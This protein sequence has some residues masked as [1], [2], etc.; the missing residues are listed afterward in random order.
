MHKI[1]KILSILAILGAGLPALAHE[2]AVDPQ[3]VAALQPGRLQRDAMPHA[4]RPVAALVARRQFAP[5]CRQLAQ[6]RRELLRRAA[7]LFYQPDRQHGS[8]SLGMTLF[9]K[10]NVE[11]PKPLLE[12]VHERLV[13]APA[14]RTLAVEACGLA[15]QPAEGALFVSDLALLAG[16]AQARLAL[17]LLR[18]QAAG[19]WSAGLGPIEAGQTGPRVALL[20]A[21][22]GH[23][24]GAEALVRE[25]G[26]LAVSSE[27]ALLVHRIAR[28]LGVAVADGAAGAAP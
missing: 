18:A 9:L 8:D 15:G 7:P 14:L 19:R 10:A 22:A 27:E 21:L 17:G 4:L 16:D 12:I 23:P 13:P 24:P 1:W 11:G 2:L 28:L 20:R 6:L 26:R 3:V 25:A 5:A